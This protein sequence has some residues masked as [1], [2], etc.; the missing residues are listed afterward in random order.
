[1]ASS[2]ITKSLKDLLNDFLKK[3]KKADLLMTYFFFLEKKYNIQPVLF[4]KEKT[5][6]QSK[7][8]I[9]KKG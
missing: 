1:M 5:I 6:Y 3:T 2:V 7:A 9:F 4:L 8:E